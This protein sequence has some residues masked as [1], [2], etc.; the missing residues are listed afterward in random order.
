MEN[1]TRIGAPGHYRL[2]GLMGDVPE[3]VE[4]IV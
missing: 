4:R 1:P 2:A 3:F